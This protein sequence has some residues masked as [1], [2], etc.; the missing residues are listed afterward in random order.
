MQPVAFCSECGHRISQLNDASACLHCGIV[1]CAACASKL[2]AS[3]NNTHG[4]EDCTHQ[5]KRIVE[6]RAEIISELIDIRRS[7]KNTALRPVVIN[8]R[9]LEVQE[10][11]VNASQK[12]LLPQISYRL[13]ESIVDTDKFILQN[14]QK[15]AVEIRKILRMISI[16][17]HT[18]K[19]DDF[20]N[21]WSLLLNFLSS[22]VKNFDNTVQSWLSGSERATSLAEKTRERIKAM[23]RYLRGLETSVGFF[24]HPDELIVNFTPSILVKTLNSKIRANLLITTERVL[25]VQLKSGRRSSRIIYSFAPSEIILCDLKEKRKRRSYLKLTVLHAP[26]QESLKIYALESQL[27]GIVRDLNLIIYGQSFK[28]TKIEPIRAW[29][30]ENFQDKISSILFEVLSEID[31]KGLIQEDYDVLAQKKSNIDI[32][33]M[34]QEIQSKKRN[35]MRFLDDFENDYETNQ[36]S[37]RDLF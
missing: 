10:F 13:F 16:E 31:E 33:G 6:W 36:K 17:N 24:P 32:L 15:F 19:I 3:L 29:E 2:N 14:L 34:H 23:D 26:N 25:L 11:L 5:I 27:N 37:P 20:A 1:V 18:F 22:N 7:L 12:Y 8:K 9:W 28:C 4:P 30:I 35:N 21:V